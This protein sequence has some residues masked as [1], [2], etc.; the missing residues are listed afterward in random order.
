MSINQ[1]QVF[2]QIERLFA[3]RSDGDLYQTLGQIRYKVRNEYYE[4]YALCDTRQIF[5]SISSCA[6]ESAV[7]CKIERGFVAVA[8]NFAICEQILFQFL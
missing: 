4:Y 8:I 3:V 6:S 5:Q 1:T 2:K 7:F